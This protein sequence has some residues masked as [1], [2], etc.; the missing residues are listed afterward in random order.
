MCQSGSVYVILSAECEKVAGFSSNNIRAV[1]I[2][3][4][5]DKSRQWIIGGILRM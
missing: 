2:R 3:F 5:S 4:R 1:L